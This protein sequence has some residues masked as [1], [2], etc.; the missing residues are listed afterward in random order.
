MSDWLTA[1][2]MIASLLGHN[3]ELDARGVEFRNKIGMGKCGGCCQHSR[4][5][6][7][8]LLKHTQTRLHNAL[9]CRYVPRLGAINSSDDLMRC[10]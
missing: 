1:Y 5:D 3:G 10:L 9:G 6:L 4:W 7:V 2:S 8:T